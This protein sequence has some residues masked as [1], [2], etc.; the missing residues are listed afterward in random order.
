[1]EKSNAIKKEVREDN[2][3]HS[4]IIFIFQNK[5]KTLIHPFSDQ[6]HTLKSTFRYNT[7]RHQQVVMEQLQQ[8]QVAHQEEVSQVRSQMGQLIETIQ[9]I[10]RGLEIMEKMHENM[11]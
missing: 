10:T 5:T 7:R 4:C 3:K 11:N 9:A 1:M 8:N 2:N 6:N